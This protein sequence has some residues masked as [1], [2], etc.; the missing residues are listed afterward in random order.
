MVGGKVLNVIHLSD[1]TWLEVE[2]REPYNDRCG[3]RV[4]RN[5]R[6][7]PDD[8]IWWQGGSAYWTPGSF[9]GR[10]DIPLKRIGYS[11]AGIPKDVLEAM[12][13]LLYA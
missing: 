5:E 2:D 3:I 8:R 10:V 13:E 6:I 4:E 1:C 7:R 12:E 11:H 9:L